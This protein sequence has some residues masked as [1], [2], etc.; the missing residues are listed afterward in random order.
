MKTILVEKN[1]EFS[2]K[3]YI[4]RSA[5][6]S[7]YST[8]IKED[9]KLVDKESG[10]LLGVYLVMPKHSRELLKALLTIKYDKN[11]RLAGLITKSRIFGF[12]PRE[13]I[14]ND[15]CTSTQLARESPKEHE[16]ICGFAKEI[17]KY[18]RKFC[19]EIYTDHE[20]I[21]KSKLLPEWTLEGTPFSS[22]IVNR[23]NAL[24]YHFDSGNFKNVYSNMVAFKSNVKGGYLSIPQY[25]IGMEIA[26]N[27]LMLFD[28]QKILHGVTPFKLLSKDAYRLSIVYYSLQQMWKCEPMTAE[29]ARIKDVRTE[30]EKKRLLRMQGQI[31]NEI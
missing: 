20:E 6:E 23:N 1:E 15:F 7:D 8:L 22:G 21:T 28:G 19:G 9:C 10:Q 30:L 24:H 16:I 29:L 14:R 5:V 25:D 3:E 12:K 17:S 13:K 31:P 4:R 11:K 27:S 2:H 26:N 18:Y